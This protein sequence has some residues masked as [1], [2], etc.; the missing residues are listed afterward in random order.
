VACSR[1]YPG[2]RLAG[3]RQTTKILVRI[4]HVPAEI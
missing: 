3:L 2:I 4:T 1:Y